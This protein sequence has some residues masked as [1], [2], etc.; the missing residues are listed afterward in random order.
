MIP[1]RFAST[2]LPGKPLLK[3]SGKYLI[4][5]V[6]EAACACKSV[7]QVIV[8]TDDSRIYR[9]VR[10]FGGN[11][12]MT[13]TEH[14]SGTDRIA[15]VAAHLESDII[16][17]LQGD[18]PEISPRA[19]E[20]MIGLLAQDTHTQVATLA[21]PISLDEARDPHLVKVVCDH[22]GYALYFS[23]AVIP[24]PRQ[25]KEDTVFLGHIGIYAYRRSFLLKYSAL[26]GSLLEEIEKL[27]QLRVLQNGYR[28]LVAITDYR[29]RGVDTLEDYRKFL[30]RIA[31]GT[32][33]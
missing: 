29:S 2:R 25:I 19:I 32:N 13:A 16:V 7:E 8:A 33:I 17:N 31:S 21:T 18:E 11:A 20:H 24:Y 6:Y 5:H 23:R 1:A 12:Q 30:A 27:E 14:Q 26:T 9:A 22:R 10:S 28:I 4:E 3:E 15:E